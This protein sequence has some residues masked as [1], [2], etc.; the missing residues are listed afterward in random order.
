M[1][2]C[3][4]ILCPVP[5]L[6]SPGWLKTLLYSVISSYGYFFYMPRFIYLCRTSFIL[7]FSQRTVMLLNACQWTNLWAKN[8]LGTIQSQQTYS[9]RKDYFDYFFVA[10]VRVF[11]CFS[12][13]ITQFCFLSV[14][15]FSF[16][17]AVKWLR[18]KTTDS[19]FKTIDSLRIN[20]CSSCIILTMRAKQIPYVQF[21]V[22]S[23]DSVCWV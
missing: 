6:L 14:R 1:S 15:K 9:R 3:E 7:V 5:R 19:D 10:Q 23:N 21:S 11:F 20:N 18:T 13:S 4:L 22:F 12:F 16:S 2:I 17:L 8:F